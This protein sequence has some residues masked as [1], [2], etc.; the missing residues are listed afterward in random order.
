MRDTRLQI[1][2]FTL[3]EKAV[4]NP[5]NSGHFM[6]VKPIERAIKV[7]FQDQCLAET[8]AAV[9][10][11]ELG[12]DLY[13]PVIY[14]P[15]QDIVGR[16]RQNDRSSHCPLKGEAIYFDLVDESANLVVADIAWCYPVPLDFA[17]ILAGLVAFYADKVA[18]EE[19]PL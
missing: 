3:P 14:I 5:G 2:A 15:R 10:V 16:L 12:R 4:V 17:S 1:A 6:R 9:R 18:I 13:D 19:A 8:Q 11:L 7:R